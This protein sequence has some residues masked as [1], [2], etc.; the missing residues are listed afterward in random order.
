MTAPSP[1]FGDKRCTPEERESHIFPSTWMKEA[2]GTE[3]RRHPWRP[4]RLTYLKG[5]IVKL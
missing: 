4:P 2:S 5:L 3:R 1:P